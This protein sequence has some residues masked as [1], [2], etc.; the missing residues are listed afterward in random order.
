MKN[1]VLFILCFFFIFHS[2]Y[3]QSN[4]FSIGM[5]LG[6]NSSSVRG[7]DFL[8]EFWNPA[9]GYLGG[10]NIQ[11]YL[12]DKISVNGSVLYSQKKVISDLQA[13]FEIDPTIGVIGSTKII[14]RW[15][16]LEIPIVL[17]LNG[18]NK[19]GFFLEVGGYYGLLI[20]R[21]LDHKDNIG[22]NPP[23]DTTNKYKKSDFGV[24]G[25]IGMQSNLSEK[26]GYSISLRNSLGLAN[27]IKAGETKLNSTQLVFGIKYFMGRNNID[28]DN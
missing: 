13:A 23:F 26:M 16:Y 1:I 27:V 25:G 12:N 15:K 18:V 20:K 6:P 5:E 10:L 17:R 9:Y 14:G 11:Y 22:G 8:K 3:S 4:G 2:S 7:D 28:S 24:V 21:E 19:K